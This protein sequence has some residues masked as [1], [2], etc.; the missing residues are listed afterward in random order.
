MLD[1][2]VGRFLTEDPIWPEDDVNGYSYVGNN[3]TNFTDPT[4]LAAYP[5]APDHSG[6]GG[7]TDLQR[8]PVQTITNPQFPILPWML[9]PTSSPALAQAQCGKL[10]PVI[11]SRRESDNSQGVRGGETIKVTDI[12]DHFLVGSQG[13]GPCIIFIVSVPI[14]GKPGRHNVL[15]SHCYPRDNPHAI[16]NSLGKLP[17]GC[18][19]AIAGGNGRD[20][21]SNT[22]LAM[23]ISALRQR[24][25]VI[26]GYFDG[27]GLW[28]DNRG[29]Y[30]AYES[31][32]KT[33]N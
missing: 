23:V 16:I 7:A 32:K 11:I 33:N 4:G 26:D 24:G 2:K 27:S 29:N 13:A 1:P 5:I 30:Y 3:P 14:Q 17:P 21:P 31:D 15:V 22:E 19:A 20:D 9:S 28:V 12:P 10:E 18:H 25:I 8:P 6:G